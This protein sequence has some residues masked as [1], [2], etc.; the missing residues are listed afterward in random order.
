MVLF[1]YL[2]SCGLSGYLTFTNYAQH[3]V[4][5]RAFAWLSISS[6]VSES[7]FDLHS[8]NAKKN[9][10]NTLYFYERGVQSPAVDPALK[11]ALRM[12]VG[13]TEAQLSILEEET[14]H[15][16]EA[17]SYMSEAQ[18]GLKAVG[19][20]DT[21]EENILRTFKRQTISPCASSSQSST[22]KPTSG[23]NQPCS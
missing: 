13:R 7:D 18:K 2:A 16:D 9:L 22:K 8:T 11:T 4:V 6:A 17:R 5:V 12:N 1:G 15:A 20:I 19:W 21:S 14:G 3:Y 10:L 23:T